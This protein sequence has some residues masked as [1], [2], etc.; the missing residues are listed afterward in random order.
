MTKSANSNRIGIKQRACTRED[1]NPDA[2][3]EFDTHAPLAAT[4][5]EIRKAEK[6]I[7][8]RQSES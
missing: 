7:G 6:K 4:K 3:S 1:E 2:P 8:H 5:H